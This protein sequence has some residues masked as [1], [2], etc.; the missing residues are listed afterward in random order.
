MWRTLSSERTRPFRF[1]I[2]KNLFEETFHKG[3]VNIKLFR[4]QKIR[5]DCYQ[6]SDE[7]FHVANYFS[8]IESHGSEV[9]RHNNLM[10]RLDRY[11]RE[12]VEL[13]IHNFVVVSRRCSTV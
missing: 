4:K 8:W 5:I 13:K 1:R 2:V 11:M 6:Y 3:Q 10:R 12:T 9:P 7:K